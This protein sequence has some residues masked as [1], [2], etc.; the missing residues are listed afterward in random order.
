MI[1]GGISLILMSVLG[2][3][4][5]VETLFT[6]NVIGVTL[7]LIAITLLPY[8]TPMMI[9]QHPA[10]PYGDPKVFGISALTM[11]LI[12]LFSHWLLGFAKTLSLLLGILAGTFLMAALGQLEFSGLREAQW[13]RFPQPLFPDLP[14]FSLSTIVPFLVAYAAVVVNGVG[15][16]YSIGE[17]VGKEGMG[18][19]VVRG[20][21]FTGLG[22]LLAGALGTI[23]TVSFGLSPGVVL[24]TRVASRFPVTLCGVFLCLLAFFQ[25]PLALLMS[26]PPSVV[27]A[28]LIA[29]MASQVGA[30]VSVLTRSGKSLEGRDYLVIGLPILVGAF[31]SILPAR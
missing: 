27:G 1:V 11:M 24:V 20:I 22:G 4:R 2:L 23:G 19:R 8:L 7:I 29:A 13:F 31:I 3:M 17:V 14:S 15:S 10:R 28:A 25:K 5:R 9:G 30:G 6:D 18:G 21:G 16:I 26:I 12:S